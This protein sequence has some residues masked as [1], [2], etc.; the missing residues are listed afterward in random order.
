MKR[1][2]LPSAVACA[3]AASGARFMNFDKAALPR[4]APAALAN[5]RPSFSCDLAKSAMERW[6]PA[7][8]PQNKE[9]EEDDNS[10]SILDFIGKDF[11]GEG[12]TAKRISAALRTI[13]AN[14]DVVVNINSPGGDLFEGIAIYNM[15]REHK[16][17]VTVRVLGV[18]ASAASVIAMA[19]DDVRVARAGF[20]MIHNVWVIGMGDRNDFTSMAEQLAVFDDALA[21]VYSAR[22]GKEKKVVAKMMDKETWLNGSQ[23]VEEGFADS[24]LSS[25]EVEEKEQNEEEKKASHNARIADLALARAG[26][27]RSERREI[28]SSF[29]STPSAAPA[30]TPSATEVAVQEAGE[31]VSSMQQTLKDAANFFNKL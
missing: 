1:T 3:F 26:Y 4:V 15:L 12:V 17:K 13:G 8:Q 21:D 18:A 5:G 9:G 7:L 10:I 20:L 19:G 6:N 31:A 14:K 23:S 24:L 2:L 11:W 22:T 16:G 28:Q 27:S 25:D 29:R 30:G